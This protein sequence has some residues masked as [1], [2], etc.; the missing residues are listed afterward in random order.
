MRCPLL[1]IT[2][3][4]QHNAAKKM[5]VEL[6]KKDGHL[7]KAEIGY[8]QILTQLIRAY[9]Q[10]RVG[11]FFENV[12]GSEALEYLLDEHQMT[13]TRAATIAGISKQNLND[14]LKGRRG[15]N[16]EARARLAAHF[17]VNAQVFESAKELRSA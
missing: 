12:N 7:S 16:R 1:P 17:K 2:N 15:L 13:Q 3:K 10:Q 11:I 5:I 8:G 9:E 6:T 14:F 4:K